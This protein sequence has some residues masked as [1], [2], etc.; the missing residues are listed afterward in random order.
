MWLSVDKW[1][2][3]EGELK[4]DDKVTAFGEKAGNEM[5]MDSF[6]GCVTKVLNAGMYEVTDASSNKDILHRRELRHRKKVIIAFGH[7]SVDKSHDRHAM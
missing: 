2:K 3:E 5:S 4:I 6:W 1:N 7:I